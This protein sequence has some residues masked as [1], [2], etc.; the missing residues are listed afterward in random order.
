MGLKCQIGISNARGGDRRSLPYVFT[1]QGVSQ[2]SA[3]LHSDLAEEIS[4]RIIWAFVAMRRFLTANA[5]LF[6]RVDAL[7][8]R[9]IARESWNTSWVGEAKQYP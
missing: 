7:E 4:V 1:E 3:V 9:Q 6:Q 5:N 2:L 8:H